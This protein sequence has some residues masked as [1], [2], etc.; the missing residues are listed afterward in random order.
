MPKQKKKR[1]QTSKQQCQCCLKLFSN[2]KRHYY[3]NESCAQ[4]VLNNDSTVLT[5]IQSI[6]INNQNQFKYIET[7]PVTHNTFDYAHTNDPDHILFDMN[8]PSDHSVESNIS[9]NESIE[10]NTSSISH[11]TTSRNNQKEEKNSIYHERTENESINNDQCDDQLQYSSHEGED[12]IN[13]NDNR[14]IDCFFDITKH[15]NQVLKQMN[16]LPVDV[17]LL[18]SIKLLKIMNDGHIASCHYKTLIDWFNETTNSM[19]ISTF[20]SSTQLIKSKK[21]VISSLHDILYKNMSSQLSMKP[22]HDVLVLPSQRSTKISKMNLIS[23]LF[24]LLTDP[25][26]MIADNL[27]IYDEDYLNPHSQHATSYS[28]IHHSSSFKEAHK[29]FCKEPY[30][31][32]VPIIPFIDGTPI[33]VYGRNKL[34]VMMFTLGVFNQTTRNKPSSWRIAGYIPD[35]TNSNS[36]ETANNDIS[37][38]KSSVE[39]RTDYH[40][41][42]GYILNDFVDLENSDGI[43]LNLPNKQNTD[44]ETYRFKFVILY[45]IGD[46]VGNDKLCDRYVSYGKQVK[47]L[48]R[49]CDCPTVDLDNF[50]HQC[51]FT[52]RSDI[53]K[54]NATDL[55]D[56]SYYKIENNALDKLSFG[57]NKYG[58]NGCLPPEPLHQLNQGVFK[59]I[60]DYFDDCITKVGKDTIDMF[61][62]FLAMNSHRQA[63]R[64]FPD[65]GLFKDGIDKCQLTGSEIITKVFMLYCCLCQTYIIEC[66]PDIEKKVKPRYKTCKPKHV[67]NNNI[68]MNYDDDN[69]NN[70]EAVNATK[71]FYKKIGHS[72][73]HLKEWIKLLE[74]TLCFDAWIN[75]DSFKMDD[76]KETY[77]NDSKADIAIREYMKLF[78]HLVDHQ[79]GNGNKTSKIHW[80]LHIPHYIRMHGPPKAYNGQTPEHC[81]SPF[82]KWAARMTQL[83]PSSL[84]EQS[85]E[86]YFESHIIQRAYDL[87]KKQNA[88][89]S[90]H[91]IDTITTNLQNQINNGSYISYVAIGRYRIHFD[92]NLQ[93]QTIEWKQHNA[94]KKSQ[95]IR[96]NMTLINDLITRFHTHEYELESKYIDCFTTLHTMFHDDK[97]KRM[98]RADTY[99]YKRPWID[100]CETKWNIQDKILKY[101]SRLLMFIDTSQM[102]FANYQNEEHPYLALIRA[103]EDDT[104]NKSTKKNKNCLLINSFECDK[105]VRL[106][107]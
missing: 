80:L 28:D 18:A 57:G 87:L 53:L 82:V 73:T 100:W 20:N 36:G 63:S 16:Y 29:K 2:I 26:L 66:L 5:N 17:S 84:I 15:Q 60:V 39:K 106:I 55:K 72:S 58:M 67:Q 103:S 54:M 86:R 78:T 24:S 50:K 69:N 27:L 56:I 7:I 25:E 65:I 4:Y 76:L 37:Q 94:K 42:L 10:S 98:Y 47:R 31:V 91:P 62:R 68:E 89:K 104:R 38:A 88:V 44:I 102:K 8:T 83:R 105:Y 21:K 81:L 107:N 59:K 97:V 99:F 64:D 35:P 34:E 92:E 19:S 79:V 6:E 41:M 90:I 70:A 9:Q 46:A 51:Q 22:Q 93:F 74:A 3:E 48:C 23:S 85:C 71:I 95:Y 96:P 52:K 14:N 40:A 75:Q 1:K 43:V 12:S 77:Q 33:D 61:V 32:L 13:P 49:D 101:P 45:I 30:D 11:N